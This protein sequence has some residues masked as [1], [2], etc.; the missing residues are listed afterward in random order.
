MFVTSL[1]S[2]RALAAGLI[3][4]A[5]VWV[6]ELIAG[7]GVLRGYIADLGWTGFAFGATVGTARAA[8]VPLG[9]ERRAWIWIFLGAVAYAV[10]R[11]FRDAYD[12]AGIEPPTP[13]ASDV[14][15]LAAAVLFLAGCVAF[16]AGHDQRLAIYALLLDVSAAVLTMLA[17]VALYVA[18]LF[19]PEMILKPATIAVGLAYPILYVAA[20]GRRPF[21]ELEQEGRYPQLE[22]RAGPVRSEEHTSELQSR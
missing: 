20:T 12:I 15:F 5:V 16:L 9:R 21:A 22:E 7:P 3:G 2:Q 18:D 13:A 14:G 1:R 6:A 11:L 4:A 19:A 8:M 17:G 10:G